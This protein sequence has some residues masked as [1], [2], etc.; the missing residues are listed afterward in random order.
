MNDSRPLAVVTGASSGI[1]YELARK[2]AGNGI[3]LVLAADES[4]L[5]IAAEECRLLGATV[6]FV[7]ADLSTADGVDKLHAEAKKVGRPVDALFANAGVTIGGAFLD[8]DFAEARKVL[9]T[10]VTGTIYLIHKIGRDMRQAGHGR[11]LIT[12]SI[13]ARLPG[14]FQSIYN[15]TKAFLGSFAPAL[16]NELKDYGITV[17]LL[18]PGVTDTS[19]FERAGML[20]TP[21]SH[22]PK[23]D[24][25]DVAATG[26]DAMMRGDA[27]VV[28]GLLNKAMA[29]AALVTPDKLLAQMHRLVAEPSSKKLR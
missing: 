13:E 26:F 29:A 11:I 2:C 8:Q 1:G 24:P 12:G 5:S 7:Q 9:E 4:S 18:M 17:T 6:A 10:N 15:G 25:A 27:E 28:R 19:V 14:A 22:A 20:D 3:D 21:I 23:S 16:R